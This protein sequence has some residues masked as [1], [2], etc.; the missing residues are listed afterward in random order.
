MGKK[1][2]ENS[3]HEVSTYFDMLRVE[4]GTSTGQ[5]SCH[6]IGYVW[7]LLSSLVNSSG[8]ESWKSFSIEDRE[9]DKNVK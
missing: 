9:N 5:S 7:Q 6:R 3:P 8:V 2:G 1:D 4:C